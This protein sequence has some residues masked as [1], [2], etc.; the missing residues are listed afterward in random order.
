MEEEKIS[1]DG[2]L[3]INNYFVD[4]NSSSSSGTGKILNI[5]GFDPNLKE[6]KKSKELQTKCRELGSIGW[7][8]SPFWEV[9][10]TTGETIPDTWYE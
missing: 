1:I 4:K 6:N 10:L 8:I 7:V 5:L 2:L 3:L 9:N